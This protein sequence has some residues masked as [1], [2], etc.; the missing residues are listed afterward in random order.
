MRPILILP[1]SF[2]IIIL[3][4]AGLLCLP[5]AVTGERLSFFDALFTAT[6]ATCV[7][8]LVV[9]DTGTFFTLFGQI[10]ILV[11]IQIGGLGLMTMAATLFYLARRKVSLFE[12]MTL[13]EGFGADHMNDLRGIAASAVAVTAISEFLGT[14]FLAIRFIPKYGFSK[15][16]WFS[17][18][19]SISAFCNAGF[20]LFGN[21]SSLTEFVTDPLVNF[22]IM[23]LIVTGGLGFVV[24]VDLWRRICRKKRRIDYRSRLVVGMTTG[25]IFGGAL[26]IA[27][28]EWNSPETLGRLASQ[29][30][31][32]AALFQ[33]VT[34]RTAG[35]N[36]IAQECQT[37]AAKLIGIVYMIIGGSPAG[38]AGGLKTMTFLVLGATVHSMIRSVGEVDLMGRR[39][40]SR[41]IK[42]ALTLLCLGLVLLF[43]GVVI[44]S[45]AHPE[46]SIIDV[47]FE[48]ASAMGTV[49]LSV[50]VTANGGVACHIIEIMLMF[51]GRIGL[52][53][54]VFA[55]SGK[56]QKSPLKYPM[57]D[58]PIG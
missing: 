23:A 7:T 5:C 13:S 35:L 37:D 42:K 21:F 34:L 11:M 55:L 28:L 16:L 24:V 17:A 46:F 50:G 29:D 22:V 9:V 41:N 36:T 49:G 58:I 18:F 52:L 1:L 20:D 3:V 56:H 51:M 48:L 10:V 27:I 12:R 14:A 2:L 54:F 19:H 53:T 31:L 8:G 6:S 15:G 39:L 4:G 47:G 30:K 33:S 26:L 43:T 44:V 25:L 40:G 32:M 38:T 45:A 57:T